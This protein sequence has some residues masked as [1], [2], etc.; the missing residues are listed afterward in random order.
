MLECGVRLEC[1]RSGPSVG[2]LVHMLP[3]TQERGPKGATCTPPLKWLT[4]IYYCSTI[5]ISHLQLSH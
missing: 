1:P 3:S 5:P 2:L 4:F